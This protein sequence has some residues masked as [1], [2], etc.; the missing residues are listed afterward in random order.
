MSDLTCLVTSWRR[1]GNLERIIARLREQ[2]PQP[3][4]W[5]WHNDGLAAP[6]LDVGWQ[7]KSS[8]NVKGCGWLAMMHML[9]TEFFCKLDDDIMPGDSTLLADAVQRLR[10]LERDSLLGPY[11][12]KLAAGR[13]YAQS[14]SANTELPATSVFADVLKFRMVLGRSAA[15]RNVPFP[16]PTHHNDL[17]VS[18]WLA[19]RRRSSHLVS[20]VFHRRLIDL[21]EGPHAFSKQHNHWQERDRI[22]QE[23]LSTVGSC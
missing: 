7:L 18:L 11:G 4:I 10:P 3:R 21:P 15:V 19:G 1:P 23:W 6:D 14:L 16:F 20:D 8:R 9:E 17:H 22:C 2:Q 13:S 12:V 5:V